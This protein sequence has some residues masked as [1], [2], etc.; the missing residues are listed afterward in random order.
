MNM[1]FHI[2]DNLIFCNMNS[3]YEIV[4]LIAFQLQV[5]PEDVNVPTHEYD[6]TTLVTTF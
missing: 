3:P 1:S 6:A 4:A 5:N 2:L